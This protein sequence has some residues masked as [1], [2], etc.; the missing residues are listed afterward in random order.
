MIKR[1][2]KATSLL[3]AAAAIISIVPAHAADYTKID[4]QEGTIY[5]A[6]AYKDGKFYVDGEV[7]DKDEAAYYLADGKYNNLSDI[8]SGADTDIYGSKYLDVQDGDYFVDLDNGSVTDESIKEN[9]EDDAAS[10]LRKNLKKDNDKRY[11]STEAETI[12][13][14]AG[15]E[16]AG[17]KFSA[18]W[19][20]FQYTKDNATNGTNTKL[21]VY[22]DAQGNYIDADYNLGSIKVTTTAA[23]G[24]T[25]KTATISNTDDTYD[26]AGETVKDQLSASVDSDNAKVIGQDANNI[27]RIA[28]VTVTVKNGSTI[29]KINGIDVSVD[30]KTFDTTVSGSVSFSV[31]QKISKAQA[32]G[33]VDG[34]K[35]AKSVTT[36]IVSDEDGKNEAF[37]YDNY[38]VANGKLVGYTANGTNVKT[39]TGTLSSKNGYYYV[40]LG[41]EASEDVQVNGSK[42]AVDTDA[43]GNLWRL[44]AGYIYEWNN[45]EDWTKVYKVD[46]SFDQ[47]SVYN[48]DNIVAWSKEDDVYSVI[49]GKGTTTP[50]DPT[51]VVNKGWVKTDAGWTFYNT[52]GTQVKGQWV[53]DGGVWYYIKADGTMAT[54]WIQDG[55]TWYYLQSSGA[56][57]TGWLN[58]NGTWYYL[59]SS[60]A[61]S[62]GWLN[63]NGTWYFLNSSGAMLAN[64]TVDG[65]KLG[66]S[67]AWIK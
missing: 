43:D 36:Y 44:D 58:D 62:T 40:D 18:P 29:A 13:D 2:T 65:Y 30:T 33:N 32:S 11:V 27:Y 10:A 35:Y 15:A 17:N 53:N 60:G 39:A 42:S 19:Y 47:M 55:S 66:A 50:T 1:M 38:T 24:T 46:G 21:N 26:A 16:I 22:T 34:A 14:L 7:N 37:T 63:D 28:K 48:K 3:V 20:K 9:A 49:G 31:I 57:K 41:D 52:D 61:M 51:P 56:M 64:T 54:G 12:Q 6:V 4:S 45:D 5:N 23:S 25:N 59:Q 67:G 8:D